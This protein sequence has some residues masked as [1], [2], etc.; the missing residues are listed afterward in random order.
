MQA[1]NNKINTTKSQTIRNPST[2]SKEKGNSI[3]D[4]ITKYDSLVIFGGLFF[5]I[6]ITIIFTG[7]F[8]AGDIVRNDLLYNAFGAIAMAFVFVY[9]IFT[10]MGSHIN[11]LG[12]RVDLGMILYIFILLFIMFILGN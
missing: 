6:L 7:L 3:L 11:I 2:T 9:L 5:A 1:T 12:K 10:F 4:F 8:V